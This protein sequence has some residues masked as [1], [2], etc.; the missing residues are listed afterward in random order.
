[1]GV[2]A[3][4]KRACHG[5]SQLPCFIF[6]CLLVAIWNVQIAHHE[7]NRYSHQQSDNGRNNNVPKQSSWIRP[8]QQ[9]LPT[10]LIDS[11]RITVENLEDNPDLPFVGVQKIPTH[12]ACEQ[13]RGVYHIAIADKGGG[14]GTALF[15]LLIDQILYAEEQ[16]LTP[17]IHLTPNVSNVIDDMAV[18]STSH[19]TISFRA[20]TGRNLIPRVQGRHWRDIVPGPLNTTAIEETSQQQ[21]N[22]TGTG[23]WGHYFEPVSAFVPGDRSCEEK[24]YATIGIEDIYLVIPGLHGYADIAV[25][26]WRYD[27]LPDYVAQPHRS[28]HVW[29]APQRERAARIVQKYFRFRPYLLQRAQKV[30]PGCSMDHHPCLGLHIRHSDKAAGRRVIDVSEFLPFCQQFVDHGGKQIFLATDSVAVL[31]EI[32]STWPIAIASMIRTTVDVIRSTDKTAVFDMASHHR[33]NQEVLV[34]I[35][36]LSQCQFMVHGHSAVSEAA[37]WIKIAL[38]STSVNLEDED[39][40]DSSQ[41]GSLVH[42]AIGQTVPKHRW[43]QPLRLEDAWPP[44]ESEEK[45][46]QEI[47]PNNHACDEHDGILLISL[48]G[49]KAA[50]GRAF[51]TSVLN[52]LIYADRY[53]LKPW[54]HLNNITSPLIYDSKAHNESNEPRPFQML[55]GAA[56]DV[57]TLAGIPNANF[58][59]KPTI[60][61]KLSQRDFTVL[62]GNGIWNTYFEPVSDFLPGDESCQNKPLIE[63]EETMIS[64]GLEVFAPWSIKAWRYDNIPEIFLRSEDKLYPLSTTSWLQPIREKA[65][66]VMQKYVRFQPYLNGRA[67]EV[68]PGVGGSNPCLGVHLRLSDKYGKFRRKVKAGEFQPYIE[69]YARAGGKVIYI[70]TDTQRPLQFM[71]K[72]FPKNITRM[73]RT[74]GDHIVRSSNGDWPTHILDDHHRVNSETLVDVLALS[75]CSIMLHGYSTV[76]EAAIYLNPSLHNHSVNLEDSS[77]MSPNDF[78]LL[79]RYVLGID[80]HLQLTRPDNSDHMTFLQVQD[81][82]YRDPV[83]LRQNR[84]TRTCRSNAIVYLA[85]KVHS[86]YGRDSY[87]QLLRSLDLLNQNYLSINDHINN[88]DIF[89]FH[90]GD[91]NQSD[92]AILEQHLG[93]PNEPSSSTYG[94]IHLVDL[95]GT[96]FWSRPIYNTH[97]DPKDWYAWPLFSEGYRRMMHWFAIDM[98]DF[99]AMYNQQTH[100]EYR[101]LF[102]MDEDSYIHS[103]I[104]YDIFDLMK[105]QK[106]VYG[107]RMCA[108]E[109]KVTQ[110]MSTMWLKRNPT[111]VPQRHFE[112]EMCGFYNNFFVADLKFFQRTDVSQFLRFIDKQGHIY[113]RRLGDLMIHSMAVYWFAP[114]EKIHRFLDFTYEHG[115]FNETNG[116]LLWGGIQAGY[117]DQDSIKTLSNYN[118]TIVLDRGCK[119]NASYLTEI[120]LSPS[121]AHIPG[122]IKGKVSLLT[123]TAGNVELPSGKGYLSG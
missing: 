27:F 66:L 109:M 38:H 104:Q 79:T 51:F 55:Q 118:E 48:V 71:Y 98:W 56:A 43:P 69:A 18:H 31:D 117:D 21:L 49:R 108:Y 105:T 24:L 44:L 113:R 81:T 96:K 111:F 10:R 3:K 17:W 40:L 7:T 61:G 5:I 110:R 33:T 37:I 54:I 16:N 100:C 57:T 41:F 59:G 102:R 97:D 107:F 50:T 82:A 86:S 115:T 1:M 8:S 42:M 63:L 119:V 114:Q 84:T 15:Q 34:E 30:N 68:N 32:E 85:Q 36:A 39:H 83:I 6:G 19:T 101:Y 72:N 88:T 46:M 25:R 65:T 20:Y 11:S 112:L 74:Q 121:Y 116:C 122:S 35:I 9:L 87:S 78:E 76:S 95:S 80:K 4:R 73:I 2:K 120:D 94:V 22:V 75:K 67:E 92:I 53:N 14:V 89:I 26:C 70:A 29:I 123:I 45:K 60:S 77:R 23:I 52:Q 90:T 28:L 64:P 12:T 106:Y 103:S 62:P 99:F 47:R 13:T 58:P 91:F 93:T